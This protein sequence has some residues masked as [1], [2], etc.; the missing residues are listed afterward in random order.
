MNCAS[1]KKPISFMNCYRVHGYSPDCVCED[2]W[3]ELTQSKPKQ[4]ELLKPT[5][6]V[7]PRR[8]WLE[9]RVKELADAIVNRAHQAV[10][11]PTAADLEPL[12]AW[13]NEIGLLRAQIKREASE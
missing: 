6:G 5:L 11:N 1:C 3:K 2:C 12:P 8:L 7:I 10:L 4:A 13:L 9:A